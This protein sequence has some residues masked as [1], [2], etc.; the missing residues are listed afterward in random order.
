MSKN[1]VS[2]IKAVLS[3]LAS[4]IG[5]QSNVNRERDFKSNSPVLF[6][7]IGIIVTIFFI[8]SLYFLVYFILG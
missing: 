5:I 6:I 7:V 2:I 3:V 8:M 1:K 4:F